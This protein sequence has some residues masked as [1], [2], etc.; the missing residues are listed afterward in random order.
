MFQAGSFCIGIGGKI[1]Q[2]VEGNLVSIVR[3]G[4]PAVA[5]TVPAPSQGIYLRLVQRWELEMAIVASRRLR[6]GISRSGA[7]PFGRDPGQQDQCSAWAVVKGA[8][9]ADQARQAWVPIVVPGL[10]STRCGMA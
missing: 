9:R 4:I 10:P 6:N 7:A 5:T 2:A 8:A 3:K 1:L